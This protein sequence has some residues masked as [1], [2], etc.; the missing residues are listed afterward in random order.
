MTVQVLKYSA[1]VPVRRGAGKQLLENSIS[2]AQIM[3]CFPMLLQL[4]EA[5]AELDCLIALA[6]AS[7]DL[8]FVR[9]EIVDDNVIYIKVQGN[10]FT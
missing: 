10:P 1:A 6:E 5:F 2:Y 7:A 4:G 3:D 8:A 9:P